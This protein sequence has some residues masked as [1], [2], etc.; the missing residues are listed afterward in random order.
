[1]L[2]FVTEETIIFSARDLLQQLTV[3][4]CATVVFQRDVPAQDQ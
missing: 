1:M 4:S 2:L 3:G